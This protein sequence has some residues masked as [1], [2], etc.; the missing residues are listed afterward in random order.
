MP[1]AGSGVDPVTL[2]LFRSRAVS[3]VPTSK[4]RHFGPHHRAQRSRGRVAQSA[5]LLLGLFR[6]ECVAD[7]SFGHAAVDS[8]ATGFLRK[9]SCRVSESPESALGARTRAV[10]AHDGAAAAL[11]HDELVVFQFPIATSDGPGREPKVVSEL[12]DRG[13]LCVRRERSLL[14]QLLDLIPKLLVRGNGRRRIDV[15]N[16]RRPVTP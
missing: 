10:V 4:K 15:Q 9:G 2:A 12:T 6:D 3:R 16:H 11:R 5:P 13:E 7:C 14:N 1:V 8:E